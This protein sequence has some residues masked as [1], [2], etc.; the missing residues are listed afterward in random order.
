MGMDQEKYWDRAASEKEFTTPFE[1]NIFNRHVLK[2]AR[3]LD[4]GCGYGR[5]TNE[6]YQSGFKYIQGVDYS[7]KMIERGS[8]LYPHLSLEKSRL[9]FDF[10]DQIFD[11]VILV[12]VLTCIVEDKS[13]N[14]LLQEIVRILK[15]GGV[16]Y[17]NDFLLN[18]D[19][20]NVQR[21]DAF[22]F[23]G[24]PYGVFELDEGAVLRHHDPGH[25]HQLIADFDTLVFKPCVYTT[26]NR[27]TSNGFYF[28]GRLKKIPAPKCKFVAQ[29]Q[30]IK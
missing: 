26:M 11:A 9:P 19:Q 20:R 21:Y 3:I 7:Q 30:P 2:T 13:Q 24:N 15:P 29:A 22:K 28:L 27:N 10:K 17:I 4:V 23:A 14:A 8:C 25:V 5:V 18:H 16:L 12:A 1:M 6:L